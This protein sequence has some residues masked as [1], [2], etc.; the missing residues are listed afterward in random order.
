MNSKD[1]SDDEVDFDSDESETEKRE[2]ATDAYLLEP[3]KHIKERFDPVNIKPVIDAKDA[4][5]DD[6]ELWLFRVPKQMALTSL[7][8]KR[9]KLHAVDESNRVAGRLRLD[10]QPHALVE[11]EPTEYQQFVNLFPSK[12]HSRLLLGKPFARMLSLIEPPPP[13][14]VIPTVAPPA[15]VAAARTVDK[16]PEFKVRY[17][18][19]GCLPDGEGPKRVPSKFKPSMP[20]AASSAGKSSKKK[21]AKSD[22]APADT[23]NKD[24]EPQAATPTKQR[25]HAAAALPVAASADSDKKG[26]RASTP[27]STPSSSAKHRTQSA[28]T[29]TPKAA[30][31]KSAAQPAA[32]EAASEPATPSK[33]KKK[34]THEVSAE[35]QPDDEPQA[36]ADELLAVVEKKKKK[37]RRK[38][39]DAEMSD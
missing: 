18:P 11:A 38:S 2:A 16:R 26:E 31:S 23:V 21:R 4:L 17:L 36:A 3:I 14:P 39:Q 35:V 12:Q 33:K 8:G 30:T 20:A 6:S 10:H 32:E 5:S 27:K 9:L 7:S 29:E 28:P 37:K 22:A 24:A 34:R 15:A 13:P 1:H 19:I 25:S